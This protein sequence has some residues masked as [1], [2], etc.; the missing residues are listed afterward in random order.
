MRRFVLAMLTAVLAAFAFSCAAP[1]EDVPAV[2]T[3][4]DEAYAMAGVYNNKRDVYPT[5]RD[6]GDEEKLTITRFADSYKQH[7]LIY[8]YVL[9]RYGEEENPYA[10]INEAIVQGIIKEL[11]LH[12]GAQASKYRVKCNSYGVLSLVI[13]LD[14][15]KTSDVTALIPMTF[16]AFTYTPVGLTE[17]FDSGNERWRALIPDIITVQAAERGLVLLNDIMPIA[18]DQLYFLT[19]KTIV[20]LYRPYEICTYT[21]QWPEFSIP[22]ERLS[23]YFTDASPLARLNLK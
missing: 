18:D 3:N 10:P 8:P 5:P 7:I 11:N 22:I 19:E 21:S 13:E 14:D 12:E 2:G 4:V 6:G 15:M 9:G 16:D 17:L 20:F 1:D 23:D